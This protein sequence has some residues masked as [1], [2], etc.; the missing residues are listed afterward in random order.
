VAA[1]ATIDKRVRS[2]GHCR[3]EIKAVDT[4]QHLA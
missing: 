4:L 2:R 1:K 3:N